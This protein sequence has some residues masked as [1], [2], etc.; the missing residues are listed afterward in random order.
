M[1]EGELLEMGFH[2][3]MLRGSTTVLF[4]LGRYLHPLKGLD[5][6]QSDR[7]EHPGENLESFHLVLDQG[8]FLGV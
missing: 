6:E 1:G 7:I 5:D 2:H 8:V 3:L 4:A